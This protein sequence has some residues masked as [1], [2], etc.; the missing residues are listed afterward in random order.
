MT[1]ERG[2]RKRARHADKVSHLQSQAK[3]ARKLA[4]KCGSDLLAEIY[5]LH[6]TICEQ[7]ALKRL[8]RRRRAPKLHA[9][10]LCGH[11]AQRNEA[12]SFALDS[13]TQ[14]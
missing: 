1:K 13:E 2:G 14:A 11:A 6:A 12:V 5:E 7:N 3:L 8:Q 4:A 10:G 9:G